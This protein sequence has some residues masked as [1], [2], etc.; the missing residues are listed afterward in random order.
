[1]A[2]PSKC[3]C[4]IVDSTMLKDSMLILTQ[5]KRLKILQGPSS[6]EENN[7]LE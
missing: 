1:M 5:K 4:L 2:G 7:D 3:M 6:S